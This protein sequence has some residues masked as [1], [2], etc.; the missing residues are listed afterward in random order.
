MT[1]S[2]PTLKDGELVGFLDFPV[3]DLPLRVDRVVVLVHSCGLPDV[4]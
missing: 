3:S 2:N 4:A 1:S